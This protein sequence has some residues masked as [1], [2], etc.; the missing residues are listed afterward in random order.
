MNEPLIGRGWFMVGNDVVPLLAEI[1]RKSPTA[2]IVYL[3]LSKFANEYGESF[4]SVPTLARVCQVG[5]RTIQEAIK[6]L[7]RAGLI[8]KVPRL[9]DH[10]RDQTN[11]YRITAK[12]YQCEGAA[13]NTSS[14]EHTL[15]SDGCS[16]PH[17]CSG[18]RGEG[19]VEQQ[20]MGVVGCT[21]KEPSRRNPFNQTASPANAGSIPQGLLDL[22]DGWNA[23]GDAI[24]KPG[25]G[26]KRNPPSKAVRAG[27]N[28]AQD[29]RELGE[30]FADMPKLFSA[31]RRAKFCHGQGWF[32]LPWL[33]GKNKNGELNAVRILAGV[34][35]GER[36]N[37]KPEQF[38]PST[39]Q[40]SGQYGLE[41]ESTT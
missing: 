24:V 35:D 36:R 29:N 25:N 9:G 1:A 5:D 6:V 12:P 41:Y 7:V 10:E 15:P 31:I 40:R 18:Q 2:A 22:I 14:A 16:V 38:E 33:F 20:G 13:Q 39:R 23:L 11:I 21:Q 27:W 19:V 4:P 28:R 37:G 26:A 3:A 32:T 30:C 17:R 8:M 34:H